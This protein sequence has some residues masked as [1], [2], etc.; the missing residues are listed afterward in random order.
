[1]ENPHLPE[2]LIFKSPELSTIKARG[3]RFVSPLPN[4][5]CGPLYS[6]RPASGA[7]LR[8]E[9]PKLDAPATARGSRGHGQLSVIRIST[10][11]H[12]IRGSREDNKRD[13]FFG[14]DGTRTDIPAIPF[15]RPQLQTPGLAAETEETD[16]PGEF[17][18]GEASLISNR[19][20][21][22]GKHC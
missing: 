20:S 4:F 9:Q 1:M 21:V 2:N 16:V 3:G 22:P 10:L 11:N 12:G 19:F 13:Q 6:C 5:D 17:F 18:D 15:P 14:D 8:G 7:I